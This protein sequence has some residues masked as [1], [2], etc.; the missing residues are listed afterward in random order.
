MAFDVGAAV[1]YLKLDIEGFKKGINTAATDF[2]IFNDST[3]TTQQKLQGL[4][5]GLTSVGGTLT[6]YVSAPLGIA[7]GLATKFAIDF[8]NGMAKANTIADT[9]VVSLDNLSKGIM[10]ISG[11]VNISN[12]ELSEALYQT[13]SATGDTANALGYVE[14]A[15]MLAKGGFTTVTKAVDGATSVLNA[16]GLSGVENF[17]K[18][19]DVMIQTQNI[20]KTTVDEL[21]SSLFNVIPTA[22]ALG[23][24]FEQV[25][26]A[27]AAITAQGTPTATATTQLRQMFVELSKDGNEASETF[28][29]FAG[30]TFKDFIA[31]GGSVSGALQI[32]E[33]A[34]RKS[35][36]SLS[37]MFGSVEA[38]NAALQLTGIGADKFNTALEGMES[39][40]GSTQK[41]FET[42]MD[43]AG[44]ALAGMNNSMRNM[45]TELGESVL[46]VLALFAEGMKAVFDAIA[47]LPDPIQAVIAIIG[48]LLIVLGPLLL[49]AG[50]IAG[51]LAQLATVGAPIA[52]VIATVSGELAIMGGFLVEVAGFI[53]SLMNPLTIFAG[54]FLALGLAIQESGMTFDQFKKDCA[55]DWEEIKEFFSTGIETLRSLMEEGFEAIRSLTTNIRNAIVTSFQQVWNNVVEGFKSAK[56]NLIEGFETMKENLSTT[57]KDWVTK[58]KEWGK[59]IPKNIWEGIKS[60]GSWLKESFD[61]LLADIFGGSGIDISGT[62]GTGGSVSESASKAAAKASSQSGVSTA[63]LESKMDRLIKVT[64]DAQ[65]RE[66]QIS[67]T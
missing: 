15:A 30:K 34:A 65:Y 54:L 55:E 26:A 6:K 5:S 3:A 21:A 48:G 31:Q 61:G 42:M 64:E 32:M 39:S 20:G 16:Y 59:E 25:G 40:A 24:K 51:A 67:R 23:V 53:A 27:L 44:E 66:R 12:V 56:S 29:R 47:S 41:A 22:S 49:F 7:G 1:G 28:K 13:I 52:G 18:V 58:F 9:S 14:Q 43:T 35:R 37:D 62:L 19:A 17:Q 60:L 45:L 63:G 33:G 57:F 8:Q 11:A 38:G 2:K 4:S 46:P 36:L 50:A 10:E